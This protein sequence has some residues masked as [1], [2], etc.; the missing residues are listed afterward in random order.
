MFN[1]A[2]LSVY[3]FNYSITIVGLQ[4]LVIILSLWA[5]QGLKMLTLPNINAADLRKVS[6]RRRH[7]DRCC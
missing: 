6:L 7:Y 3:K 1:K 4:S 2:V 5:L